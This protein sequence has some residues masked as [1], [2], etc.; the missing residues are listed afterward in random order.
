MVNKNFS[1]VLVILAFIS[2]ILMSACS[3]EE[4]YDEETMQCIA[5]KSTLYISTGCTACAK[6]EGILE[7]HLNKFTIIDCKEDAQKC[8]DEDITKVPTWFINNQKH[9]GVKQISEL[10]ELTGC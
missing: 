10:K 4:T 9:S 8:L 5:E 6:Q 7:E 2:L 3:N 1:K